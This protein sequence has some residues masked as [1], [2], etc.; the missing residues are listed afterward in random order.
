MSG[1]TLEQIIAEMRAFVQQFKSGG[2][3]V[4]K[5]ADRLAR[6]AAA[7]QPPENE[8]KGWTLDSERGF[9]DFIM[10]TPRIQ[11]ILSAKSRAEIAVDIVERMLDGDFSDIGGDYEWPVHQKLADRLAAP[12]AA[13][14]EA[15]EEGK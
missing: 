12:P 11:A 3:T 4:G 8:R 9:W 14:P 5:W 7:Q 6:L 1:D 2:L 10:R 15:G 13:T